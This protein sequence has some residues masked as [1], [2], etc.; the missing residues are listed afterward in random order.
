MANIKD[1]NE[2]L[3]EF[4]KQS[5]LDILWEDPQTFVVDHKQVFVLSINVF[6]DAYVHNTE[7]EK[8]EK[9][10]S[11]L[12]QKNDELFQKTQNVIVD[13]REYFSQN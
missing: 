10:A 2:K 3:E 6:R 5:K 13:L 11:E 8:W 9:I 7:L 12:K 4:L 1:P